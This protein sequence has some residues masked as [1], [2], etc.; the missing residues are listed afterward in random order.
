MRQPLYQI[1]LPPPK[2]ISRPNVSM[3]LHAKRNDIHQADVT[4]TK[5]KY[6][7]MLLISWTFPVGTKDPTN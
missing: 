3:S 7:T 4:N 6:M 1:Y 5:R 2:Y